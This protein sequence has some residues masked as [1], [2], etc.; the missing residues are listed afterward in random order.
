MVS[1]TCFEPEGSSSGRRLYIQAWYGA[2]YMHHY[3]QSCKWKNKRNIK[4]YEA[5][6][7]NSNVLRM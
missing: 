4:F 2:F 6:Y 7:F 1:A 3:K 5:V